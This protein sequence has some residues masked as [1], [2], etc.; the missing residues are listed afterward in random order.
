MRKTVQA[1]LSPIR[2]VANLAPMERLKLDARQ[3]LADLVLDMQGATPP[4][5]RHVAE[6]LGVL[7]PRLY[8]L[9]DAAA[10]VQPRPAWLAPLASYGP[11]CR[12]TSGDIDESPE[13]QLGYILADAWNPP[14]GL[15]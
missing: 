10:L 12:S 6:A 15:A 3:I 14:V 5:Q 2:A 9:W 8:N 7:A 11:L 13:E 1:I 4:M